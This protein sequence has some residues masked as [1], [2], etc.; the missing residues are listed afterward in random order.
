MIPQSSDFQASGCIDGFDFLCGIVKMA[1][2]P[3]TMR[4]LLSNP[5][6]LALVAYWLLSSPAINAHGLPGSNLSDGPEDSAAPTKPAQIQFDSSIKPLPADYKLR[7]IDRLRGKTASAAASSSLI[8]H[9]MSAAA[10]K[11]LLFK[12]HD[13]VII[14]DKSA[15]MMAEDCPGGRTRWEWCQDQ[16][17]ALAREAQDAGGGAITVMVFSDVYTTYRN[18]GLDTLAR[19]FQSNIP[20]GGT[21]TAEPLRSALNEYFMRGWP[22]ENRPLVV[23][24][25]SD[26]RPNEPQLVKQVV[27]DAT[28]R[29]RNPD[30]VRITFLQVGEDPE[31]KRFARELDHDMLSQGATHDIVY[32]KT[33]DQL[34]A[35]GV[36]GAL[37]DAITDPSTTAVSPGPALDPSGDDAALR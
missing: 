12:K 32:S 3:V 20:G 35:C 21:N 26:G 17:A 37:L 19:I 30:E 6:V 22:E 27:A 29:M 1:G 18:C 33:F 25:I 2:K 15:S 13:V 36:T 5:T 28:R 14:I 7:K 23:A 31:G 4:K 16:T 11:Q 8:N 24:I 10:A 34:K 9:T